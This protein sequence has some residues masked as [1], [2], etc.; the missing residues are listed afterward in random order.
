MTSTPS[1][2]RRVNR[3]YVI[4]L[5]DQAERMGQV[6]ET[7]RR[8]GVPDSKVVRVDAVR[9]RPGWKGC[10]M[11]HLKA[12][13]MA[14]RD[15]AAAPAGVDY[16]CVL[17]DD[18]MLDVPAGT[19]NAEIDRAFAHVRHI[20][21]LYLAMTPQ[22][23][24]D[25][26]GRLKRVRCSLGGAGALYHRDMLPRMEHLVEA[27]RAANVAH[28][29]HVARYQA[30]RLVFGF[31]KPIMLQRPGYSSIEGKDV[32]YGYLERDGAMLRP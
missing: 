2:T 24:E 17:E 28:D 1:W 3:F 22:R 10:T 18:L 31:Y 29:M 4:N 27:S 14:R 9:R 21:A 6:R 26:S 12:L 5:D 16:A 30:E 25:V 23:I 15:L 19:A 32:D 13:R 11:S 8:L 7:L 20:D